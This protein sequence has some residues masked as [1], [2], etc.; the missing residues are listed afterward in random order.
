MEISAPVTLAVLGAAL[1]HAVWNALVKSS[2]D[3][4]LDVTGVALGAAA[5]AL[6]VAPWLALPAR[7][8]WGW[9][10]ASAAAQARDKLTA[11]PDSALV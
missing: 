2:S 11:R 4:L 9:L 3:K 10:A 1:L 6:A 5:C 7:E 8:S